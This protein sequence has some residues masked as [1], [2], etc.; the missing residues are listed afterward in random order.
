ML[1][2]LR[3]S[4]VRA[5][6]ADA[7]L[8]HHVIQ[9]RYL[10]EHPHPVQLGRPQLRSLAKSEALYRQYY[11]TVNQR[12]VLSCL[13]VDHCSSPSELPPSPLPQLNLINPQ[14]TSK[15][16]AMSPKHKTVA[17]VCYLLSITRHPLFN[18]VGPGQ[19]EET[20]SDSAVAES[21]R[22]GWCTRTEKELNESE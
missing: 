4:V 9:L 19:E 15:H 21:A 12:H 20:G 1:S 17:A 22:H 11:H 6:T 13:L 5:V 14:E 8:A 10:P 18:P 3:R 16:P 2:F 7:V